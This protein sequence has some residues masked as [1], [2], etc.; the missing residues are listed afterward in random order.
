MCLTP[1]KKDPTKATVTREASKAE[2]KNL[3]KS[4]KAAPTPA[5]KKLI[6]PESVA[7]KRKTSIAKNKT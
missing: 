4:K 7:M 3:T 2:K 6:Q 1:V 5:K